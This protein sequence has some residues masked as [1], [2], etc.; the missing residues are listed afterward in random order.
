MQLKS[1]ALQTGSH[2]IIKS[3][4]VIRFSSFLLTAVA[5][6]WEGWVELRLERGCSGAV[7][8]LEAASEDNT[9]Q[10]LLVWT[11]R[12]VRWAN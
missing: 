4:K 5:A 7:L 12:K 1:F 9:G 11:R 3:R 2:I 8:S 10:T 6:R